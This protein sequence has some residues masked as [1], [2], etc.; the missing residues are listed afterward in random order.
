MDI[1]E[2]ILIALLAASSILCRG[3][4]KPMRCVWGCAL[5]WKSSGTEDGNK[6]KSRAG[7]HRAPYGS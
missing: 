2:N 7:Q 5:S 1:F 6:G 3:H 4:R